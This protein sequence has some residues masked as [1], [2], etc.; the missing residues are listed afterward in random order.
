L[1]AGKSSKSNFE[2]KRLSDN[3]LK[4]Q[5]YKFE[6]D[7]LKDIYERKDKIRKNNNASINT[8]TS[9]ANTVNNNLKKGNAFNSNHSCQ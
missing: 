4:A 9:A 1:K 5:D 8:N 2:K 6:D 3:V 7:I